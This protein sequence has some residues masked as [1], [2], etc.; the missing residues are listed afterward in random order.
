MPQV[1]G[2]AIKERAARLRASGEAA[3]SRHLAAQTGRTHRVLLEAADMGRTEQFTE[4]RF[5]T[6]QPVGQIVS[7]VITGHDGHQLVA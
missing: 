1:D 3:V 6:A 5:A 4:V 2:R 7:T